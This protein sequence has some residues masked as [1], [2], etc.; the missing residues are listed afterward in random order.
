ML[1][2]ETGESILIVRIPLAKEDPPRTD[3]VNKLQIALPRGRVV[4]RLPDWDDQLP[5]L[6]LDRHLLDLLRRFL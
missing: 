2:K 5:D 4:A 1:L 6:L 3:L